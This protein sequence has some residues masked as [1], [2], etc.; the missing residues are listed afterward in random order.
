MSKPSRRH[1]PLAI[2]MV[3]MF[4][5]G[6]ACVYLIRQVTIARERCEA[7]PRS[8]T[9]Y[10]GYKSTCVCFARGTVLP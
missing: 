6:L 1:V 10:C 7:P 3:F 5:A 8:G 2:T 4:L 9:Y